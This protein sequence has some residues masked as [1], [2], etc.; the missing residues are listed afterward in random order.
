MRIDELI[1]V[2]AF[3]GF[4]FAVFAFE[5]GYL[6]SFFRTR[7]FPVSRMAIVVHVLAIAGIMCLLYGYFV[8]PYWLDVRQVDIVTDKLKNDSLTVVQVSDLHCDEKM[9]NEG[10]LP[11]LINKFDPDVVV[12]TGDALNTPKA[13]PVFRNTL[14]GIQ[15]NI[16]KYA[17]RGNYDAWY[18]KELD[19]FG[20][21]GFVEL[22]GA[23]KLFSK[24]KE[25][26]T[27]SGVSAGNDL[28]DLPFPGN[29]PAGTYNILLFH[30]PED[31]EMLGKIP[32]DL[33]LSGHTHGGQVAL[34]FYGA[35]ITFSKYGK[36]YEAGRYDI[37]G[38][39]LYV[40]RGI[41]MEGGSAPRVRF[42]SRPEVTV[43]HIRPK[44]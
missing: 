36:K 30:Y 33:L 23:T 10:K 26:F 35:L 20:G 29:I 17:V 5:A 19:L 4:C 44:K 43:F 12:F 2:L 11:A 3:M 14:S 32:I 15:A 9:R 8:E 31:N 42:F 40:N 39:V 41:G 18:W 1:A 37:G 27:I 38:K 6:V 7:V 28:R 21:T 16:G 24:N 22:D 34:P 25:A 13:L